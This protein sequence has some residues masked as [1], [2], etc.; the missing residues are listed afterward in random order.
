MAWYEDLT[1]CGYFGEEAAGGCARSA[2]LRQ[3]GLFYVGRPVVAF[4]E[5][6]GPLRVLPGSSPITL[7]SPSS[8][9]HQKSGPF[10]PPALPGIDARTTPSDSRL[11]A[12]CCDVEVATLALTGLP[13][14]PKPPFRRAV[15][16]TPADRA[17]ARVDCFPARA[18]FPK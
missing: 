7:T 1:P 16:T 3:V 10:A 11:A 15:P 9:A 14:L 12:A 5:G 4:S 8:K 18:A 13:R 6:S 2:G 17:G